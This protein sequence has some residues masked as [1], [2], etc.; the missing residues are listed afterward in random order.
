MPNPSDVTTQRLRLAD[1]PARNKPPAWRARACLILLACLLPLS[2]WLAACSML[3]TVAPLTPSPTPSASE[4][5][6]DAM[7]TFQVSIPGNTPLRESIFLTILDEVTGLALNQQRFEMQGEDDFHYTITLPFPFGSVIKY[8]YAR[9][10]TY[11]APEHTSLKVPVRYRL[12]FVDGP[13]VVHDVVSAWSDTSFSGP[14]GRIMGQALDAD[15]A[16]PIPGLLVTAGGAQTLTASDGSFLLE[17]LPPG[18]HTLVL[19]ALDGRYATFAQG[20]LVAAESTTPAQVQLSAAPLIEVTFAA[21]PPAGTMPGVPI[22]LAGDLLQLGNTF[23]DLNGGMNTLASRLPV[24]MPTADGRYAVTVRL[25]VGAEISYKYTLGD[26]FWNAEHDAQGK[27]RL[28]H[29]TISQDLVLVSDTIENWGAGSKGPI[30]FE[31][32]V[33]PQTPPE[34]TI[35]IQLNPFGWTE[36]LPMW[37]LPGQNRW[38]YVLYSPLAAFDRL[39]YRF[40]RNDQCGSADDAATPGNDHFGRQ[41]EVTEEGQSLQDSVSG[42][43]WLGDPA[44]AAAIF[45]TEVRARGAGFMAGVELLPA[46]HPSWEPRLPQALQRVKADGAAWIVLTP[47]W[48]FT[49]SAPPL[50]EPVAGADPFPVGVAS[51]A[52]LAREAGLNLA[53]FPTPRFPLPAG[54]WWAGSPRDFPWWQAWFNRY[55]NFILNAIDQAQANSAQ[56]FILGGDWVEP[57]LPD[58]QIFDSTS[59]GVPADAEERWRGLIA[60]LR[61]RFSGELLWALPY[62]E[63]LPH[64]P[65][66]LDAVDGIYLLWSLPLAHK[67]DA[68][69]PSLHAEAARLLDVDLRPFQESLGKPLVLAV[70]Y[71]S[72][73]GGVTGCLID[74]VAV[75]EGA[76]LDLALLNR[77]NV[78]V[79]TIAVDLQEQVQV[80]NALLVAVNERDFIAGFVAR[81]FYPPAALA[82][83]S[84]SVHGKP[85][86]DVL[87]FWF[88]RLLGSAP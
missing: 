68:D 32:T 25:P 34:D 51:A 29:L 3:P 16:Q 58:G 59:S 67:P 39:G 5:V 56:V 10:G 45:P 84:T 9:Q 62:A 14:T 69:E 2:G 85:A 33:P 37:R 8:R 11:L 15:S 18:Q 82:D 13:G 79:P 24:L 30:L 1:R 4:S 88:P 28:R 43:A 31:L 66:F 53:V 81:G 35:S 44:P 17:G 60:N 63:G 71:P 75:I 22:R 55:T 36:P 47:T 54:E 72:A 19:S 20:A 74:P 6:P 42:W 21:T 87:R 27:F 78:D 26:G 49:R 64:L 48:T 80:Y 52:A 83:K 50:L 86:E 12:A 40:C 46:Y 73:D 41:L 76:C 38:A 7:L 77:P 65:P 70:G 61:Q 23:A 57:A